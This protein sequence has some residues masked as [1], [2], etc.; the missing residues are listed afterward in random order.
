MT[1]MQKICHTPSGRAVA[2][3]PDLSSHPCPA[4]DLWAGGAVP[5]QD[6]LRVNGLKRSYYLGVKRI[7]MSMWMDQ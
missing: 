1:L 5:E 7:R 4:D 6:G 3:G 2:R